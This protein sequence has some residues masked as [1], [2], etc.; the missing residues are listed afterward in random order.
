VN[1]ALENNNFL[2]QQTQNLVSIKTNGASAS[3]FIAL[4]TGLP[5]TQPVLG[6]T[7]CAYPIEIPP[8]L[9]YD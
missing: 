6:Q 3:S 5:V 4:C 2:S 8:Y 1:E 7:P 9:V